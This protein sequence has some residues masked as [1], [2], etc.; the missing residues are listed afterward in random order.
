MAAPVPGT[1]ATVVLSR[2]QQRE[3]LVIPETAV[4]YAAYGTSVFVVEE[5]DMTRGG[6]ALVV[7]QAFVRLGERRGD[8]V[9]VL[10]G[11]E[12]GARVAASGVFKLQDGFR[13]ILDA[14]AAH[15]AAADDTAADDTAADDA[16]ADED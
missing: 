4:S 11:V 13:V 16:D 3:V 12:E 15:D 7:R 1:Y 8:L 10:A 2:A 9:E 14:T 6:V 5:G